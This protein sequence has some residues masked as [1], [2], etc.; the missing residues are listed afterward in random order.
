ML[1]IGVWNIDGDGDPKL[2]ERNWSH[3]WHGMFKKVEM[4]DINNY[5]KQYKGEKHKFKEV[6]YLLI[7]LHLGKLV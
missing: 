6:S 1:F 2:S 4:E 3:Y 5:E 7:K